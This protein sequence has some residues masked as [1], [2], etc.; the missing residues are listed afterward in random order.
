MIAQGEAPPDWFFNPKDIRYPNGVAGTPDRIARV[1]RKLFAHGGREAFLLDD[2]P[3]LMEEILSFAQKN[4][5]G[6]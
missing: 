5:D 6:M 1:I 2:K 4:F 3:E